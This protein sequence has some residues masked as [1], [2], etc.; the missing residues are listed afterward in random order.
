MSNAVYAPVSTGS[1][2]T[3]RGG[4]AM[5]DQ[6]R[7]RLKAFKSL[8]SGLTVDQKA[9]VFGDTGPEVAGGGPLR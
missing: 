5:L 2:V 9:V 4:E 8:T 1:P 3:C 7:L 6:A